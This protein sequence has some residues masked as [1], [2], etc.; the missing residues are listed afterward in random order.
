MIKRN[1]KCLS[2]KTRAE[3]RNPGASPAYDPFPTKTG[4]AGEADGG[5]NQEAA[6]P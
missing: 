5:V 3:M 6:L 4:G 1:Q 2:P